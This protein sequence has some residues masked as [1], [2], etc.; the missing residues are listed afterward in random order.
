MSYDSFDNIAS[1][2]LDGESAGKGIGRPMASVT[3]LD[4]RYCAHLG[5]TN[6]ALQ[7]IFSG[8]LMELRKSTARY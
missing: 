5:S 7:T 6:R 2:V 1:Y 3:P 8:M 4:C